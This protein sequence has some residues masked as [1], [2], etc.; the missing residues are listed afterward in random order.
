[1]ALPK[2]FM[3]ILHISTQD[4]GG[5]GGSFDAAYRLHRNMLSA[6]VDSKMLVLNKVSNDDTVFSVSTRSILIN[7]LNHYWYKIK[8]KLNV[9]IF[10]YSRY[11]YVDVDNNFS[12]NSLL[13]RLH[14]LPDVIIAHWISGFMTTANL[15]DLNRIT[16][17]PILWYFMDMAPMTGGCHYMLGCS[18]FRRECGNCPQLG[19]YKGKED[20]SHRQWKR[21]FLSVQKT[22]ITPVIASSWQEKQLELSSIFRGKRSAVIPLG[23]DPDIFCPKSNIDAKKILGFP[24]SRRV[25]F[26]GAL[27]IHEERKGIKYLISALDILYEMLENCSLQ[28]EILVVTAG[29]KENTDALNIQFEHRSIGFLS[30]DIALATA[31]QASDVFVCSSIEDAGP[32]MINESIMC[33]TPV[34]SFDVGVAMDLVQTEKTGYRAKLKDESDMASGLLKILSLDSEAYQV[35]QNNCRNMGLTFCHPKV[36]VKAFDRL[37]ANLLKN[38]QKSYRE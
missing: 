22:D 29:K 7:K 11:F 30:G 34:V 35:M 1:M 38:K 4:K 36:Q 24:A 27:S 3:K 32:M 8:W 21:K 12:V 15:H 16:G 5:G 6:G 17:A 31:Y 25:I 2:N 23:I 20:I 10:G 14:F 28:K 37:C 13:K 26:F 19:R 33:G 9:K 18:G